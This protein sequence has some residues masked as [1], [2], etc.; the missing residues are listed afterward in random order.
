M[1]AM[2]VKNWGEPFTLE[3]RPDPE[4]G[5]GE[6]VMKVRAAGVGLTLVTM[7]DLTREEAERYADTGEPLDKAGAYAI[8]G[9]GKHFVTGLAGPRSNVIGLPLKAIVPA[10]ERA[11]F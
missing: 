1:R 6:A 5:P 7:R 9:E 3:E 2:V 8:Q 10:L 11:G 4:P